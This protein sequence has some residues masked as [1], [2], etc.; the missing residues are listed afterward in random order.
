[1]KLIITLFF[2][3]FYLF[4]NVFSLGMGGMEYR[5]IAHALFVLFL[6]SRR[7]LSFFFNLSYEILNW[8]IG[9]TLVFV[10]IGFCIFFLLNKKEYIAADKI[11]DTEKTAKIIL[12]F[13]YTIFAILFI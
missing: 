12:A 2:E 4:W 10:Y 11:K 7:T 1:M 3:P 5:A 8:K 9:I 13:A 6:V